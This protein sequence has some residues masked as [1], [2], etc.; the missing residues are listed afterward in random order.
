MTLDP[1]SP[2]KGRIILP[3]E[4]EPQPEAPALAKESAAEAPH[5]VLPPGVDAPEED[6]PEYPRLRP[7]EM[8][9]VRDQDRD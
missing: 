5:I 6:L 8:V 4:P 2:R 3:G 1:E 7:L 9:P